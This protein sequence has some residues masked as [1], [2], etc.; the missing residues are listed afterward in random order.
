MQKRAFETQNRGPE[1]GTAS[2][3]LLLVLASTPLRYGQVIATENIL[4]SVAVHQ[5]LCHPTIL[6]LFSTFPA[7]DSES[8]V[9]LQSQ[10]QSATFTTAIPRYIVL[11]YGGSQGTLSD[12]FPRLDFASALP[13]DESKVRGVVKTL[14]DAL[15]YLEKESVVHRKLVPDSVYITEDFRVVSVNL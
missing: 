9:D 8:E 11:E 4:G 7:A 2:R 10:S 6:S 1:E 15:A 3:K 13:M 14:T 5:S 12:H